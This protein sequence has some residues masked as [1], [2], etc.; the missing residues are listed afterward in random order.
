MGT[1]KLIGRKV[2]RK[3]SLKKLVK[4]KV[5]KKKNTSLTKE[6]NVDKESKMKLQ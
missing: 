3:T 5:K 6:D 2:K 1:D 4:R